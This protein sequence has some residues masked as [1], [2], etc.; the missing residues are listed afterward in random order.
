MKTLLAFLVLSG[1]AFCQNG[2]PPYPNYPDTNFA[3]KYQWKDYPIDVNRMAESF[4]FGANQKPFNG[5]ATVPAPVRIRDAQ[6]RLVG[7]VQM[8]PNGVITVRN[9][10]GQVTQTG[11]VRAGSITIRP[12]TNTRK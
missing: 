8:R 12:T 2:F 3:P 1:T 6:G 4:N 5:V 7:N 10:R 11:T 9:R